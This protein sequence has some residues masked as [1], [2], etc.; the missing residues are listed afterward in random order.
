MNNSVLDVPSATIAS[1]QQI[2][3]PT[4]GYSCLSLPV[5]LR[6]FDRFLATQPFLFLSDYCMVSLIV[7]S[8]C[9]SLAFSKLVAGLIHERVSEAN[10]F[11]IDARETGGDRG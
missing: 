1:N 10:E 5:V 7:S 2:G 8:L 11:V 9:N 3:S 6:L 4:T